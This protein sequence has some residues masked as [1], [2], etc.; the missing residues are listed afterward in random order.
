[1]EGR[2][3]TV[4]VSSVSRILMEG[5]KVITDKEQLDLLNKNVLV[6]VKDK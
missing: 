6:V 2:T 5:F 4:L 1:M 3:I